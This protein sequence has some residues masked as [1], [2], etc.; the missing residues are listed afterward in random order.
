MSSKYKFRNYSEDSDRITSLCSHTETKQHVE[1][2]NEQRVGQKSITTFNNT[3]ENQ[4]LMKEERKRMQPKEKNITEYLNKENELKKKEE[5]QE[6]VT[7]MIKTLTEQK[8]ELKK[9]TQVKEQMKI[10]EK[11]IEENEVQ[12]K[13]L[14]DEITNKK[15]DKIA[16][17]LK[18][19]KIMTEGNWNVKQEIR[20]QQELEVNTCKLLN[21]TETVLNKMTHWKEKIES[22]ME[23]SKTELEEVLRQKDEIHRKFQ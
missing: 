21:S 1:D 6:D 20:K 13:T 19:K 18:L 10:I 16:G 23:Q 8:D 17:Y 2:D 11:L 22:H 9:V 5:E 14:D 3:T 7:Q 4:S 15:V 12:I